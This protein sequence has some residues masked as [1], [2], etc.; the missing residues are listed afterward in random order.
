MHWAGTWAWR[1]MV[2]Q[3]C[4]ER[5]LSSHLYC[6]AWEPEAGSCQAGRQGG[7]EA[8]GG[9]EGVMGVE[10]PS[11]GRKSVLASFLST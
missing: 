8:D 11:E 5:P 9:G 6:S 3:D 2:K 4:L 7:R 10:E 1:V